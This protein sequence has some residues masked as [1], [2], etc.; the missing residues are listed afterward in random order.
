ML[1]VEP[2]MLNSIRRNRGSNSQVIFSKIWLGSWYH[3]FFG[4]GAWNL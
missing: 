3:F 1:F 4:F 2:F